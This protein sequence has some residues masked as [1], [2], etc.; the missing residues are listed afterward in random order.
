[1]SGIPSIWLSVVGWF[2][3][4]RTEYDHTTP[5]ATVALHRDRLGSFNVI[6]FGLVKMIGEEAVPFSK[7]GTTTANDK[8]TGA[9]NRSDEG[10]AE[11]L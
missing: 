10:T 9:I 11:D 2:V 5:E 4:A 3:E 1:M 8:R 6:E 7:N